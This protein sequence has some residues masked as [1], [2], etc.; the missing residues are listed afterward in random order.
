MNTIEWIA[1][2]FISL[3]SLRALLLVFKPDR[4]AQLVAKFYVAPKRRY[5]YLV[6]FLFGAGFLIATTSI[7][8]FILALVTIGALYDYLFALFPEQAA[9]LIT[10]AETERRKVWFFALVVPLVSAIWLYWDLLF[11]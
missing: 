4:H 8:H 10:A 3:F 7:A 6:I 5:L 11:N 1:T 2:V 9:V